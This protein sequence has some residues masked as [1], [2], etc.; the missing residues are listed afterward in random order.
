MTKTLAKPIT[1]G[2]EDIGRPLIWHDRRDSVAYGVWLL[3]LNP[4][5][6]EALIEFHPV[7]NRTKSWV[8]V[9]DLHWALDSVQINY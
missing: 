2:P 6:D 8:Q 9:G 5:A 7:L 4:A 3:A 1:L